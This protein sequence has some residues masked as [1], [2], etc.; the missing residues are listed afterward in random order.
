MRPRSLV[1]NLYGDYVRYYGGEIG[2]QNLARLLADFA[3]S[4]QT[5][6]VTL[7]RL[8]GEGWL[9]AR[10]VGRRSWYSLTPRAWKV[11]DEGR[12][13]IFK[14]RHPGWSGDWHMIIYSIPESERPVR[15]QLRKVLRWHGFGPLGPSTWI[16]P[17]DRFSELAVTLGDARINAAYD[18][19]TSQTGCLDRDREL[20]ARCWDLDALQDGYLRF[21]GQYL[22]YTATSVH[23]RSVSDRD[24]FIR[25][26]ELVHD[27]RKFPFMDPDLPLDLLPKEWAGLA[28]HA[29]F[30]DTYEALRPPA[31]RHFESVFDTPP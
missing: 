1:F 25:R 24:C 19:F 2:L 8:K 30:L 28:A 29:L 17:H 5:A 7:S 3:I 13:R 27:Y 20:A 23:G 9:E 10:R 12:D 18:T 15:E 11:L 6:R 4:E 31:L 21:R 16:S 22:R 26:V 14:R